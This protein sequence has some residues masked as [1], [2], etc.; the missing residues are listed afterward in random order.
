[1]AR[2]ITPQEKR[3][4]F[5]NFISLSSLQGINYLLPILV[6]PYLIR[7]IGPE[8]FGLIAFAQA[9]VQYFMIMTDYGFSLSATRQIAICRAN[10][11]KV[12][13]IFSSV[14]T[15]KIILSMLCFL[16]LLAIIQFIPRFRADWAVYMLSFGAV[17]GN[18]LFPVWF[19]Q[20]KEKMFYIAIINIIGGII[21]AVCIILLV[22]TPEDYLW[23]P[24]LNSAFF[25]VTGILGLYAAF[26]KFGLE[27]I[28]QTY[29]DL[30]QEFKA[31]WSIFISIVAINAYTASRVFAVGLLTN[32]VLT[33]Y[34][35]IAEKIAGFSQAFPLDSLSQAVY[36]RLNKIFAK[37]RLRALKLMR[38]IQW[39]T[40]FGYLVTLP[41][42][43]VAAPW[44]VNII[45]GQTYPEAVMALRL[46]LCA[47]FFVGAN[48]FQVQFLLVCGR[49]DLYSKLHVAA[50]IVGLPL[51]F[52]CIYLCSYLGAAISTIILETAII[53]ATTRMLKRLVAAGFP[54]RS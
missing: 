3:V 25:I 53:I 40:T 28:L 50:A 48:A 30:H 13:S 27:F 42:A 18:T 38:R 29:E 1:M 5:K 22:R 19:F 43:F 21:Y 49:A 14:M 17:L 11:K 51:I 26:R 4:V 52:L 9:F 20:G 39:A 46:L 37:N 10:Q 2:T 44:I 23:V 45:C 12:C 35:S 8:K 41:I 34:Y 24:L 7:I 32:N 16:M 36:P 33:G 6:L 31:G 47:V 15:V 54:A